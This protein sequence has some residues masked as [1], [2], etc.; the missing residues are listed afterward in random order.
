[1]NLSSADLRAV[2]KV[3]S[4]APADRRDRI[5]NWIT[6]RD[7]YA[8]PAIKARYTALIEATRL[9]VDKIARGEKPV[10]SPSAPARTTGKNHVWP[11]RYHPPR[12]GQTLTDSPH[13]LFGLAN[14]T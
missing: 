10:P 12:H 6:M 1:M 5:S 7:N 4:M 2:T 11:P 13:H 3:A 14:E 9:A 8:A